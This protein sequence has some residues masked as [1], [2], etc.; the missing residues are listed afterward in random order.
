M[1]QINCYNNG[2]QSSTCM[3]CNNQENGGDGTFTSYDSETA[4]LGCE[5]G[6]AFESSP[7][8][9]PTKKEKRF[10]ENKM[11]NTQ[12]LRRGKG[13]AKLSASGCG[14]GSNFSGKAKQCSCGRNPGGDCQC[15]KSNASG[16]RAGQTIAFPNNASAKKYDMVKFSNF[17]SSI[18]PEKKNKFI[19]PSK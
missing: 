14:C 5:N 16:L 8:G 19:S 10:K 7:N 1:A 13:L 18:K 3:P 4:R 2:N 11:G 6:A 9:N 17:I 15:N 12:G